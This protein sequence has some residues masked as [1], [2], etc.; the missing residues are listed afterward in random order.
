MKL[1]EK[2]KRLLFKDELRRLEI[3]ENSYKEQIQWCQDR[4]D[5]VYR[6]ANRAEMRLNQSAQEYLECKK[7]INEITDIA[8]D[9]GFHNEEHSWAVVCVAGKLEYV[10]FMPLKGEEARDLIKFLKQFQYSNRII[11]SPFGFRNMINNELFMK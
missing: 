4:A 7:M 2:V 10:K 9:V 8:V 11:D 5:D 1:K 6:Q 3:L